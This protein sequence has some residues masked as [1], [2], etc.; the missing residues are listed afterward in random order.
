MGYL[1]L[2]KSGFL[3]MSSSSVRLL[4]FVITPH[5]TPTLMRMQ[6][7]LMDRVR[8]AVLAPFAAGVVVAL[9]RFHVV[10][11]NGDLAFTA[12]GYSKES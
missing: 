10:E 9:D 12:R 6:R 4:S 8:R 7:L 2:K 1:L 3:P 5:L 11:E